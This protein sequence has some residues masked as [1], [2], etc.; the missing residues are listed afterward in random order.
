M[1]EVI[2]VGQGN[3]IGWV[4]MMAEEHELGLRGTADKNPS[5][6]AATCH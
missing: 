3:G 5:S 6:A 1:D 4:G 2:Y